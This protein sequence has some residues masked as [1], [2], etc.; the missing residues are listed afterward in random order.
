MAG[1]R[2]PTGS[3]KGFDKVLRFHLLLSLALRLFCATAI[4]L[5]SE[6]ILT[7]LGVEQS[8]RASGISWSLPVKII[9]N[10][11]S[12]S[13]KSVSCPT[14]TFCMAV[15]NYGDAL[16]YNDPTWSIPTSIDG[17]PYLAS[18]SCPTTTFCMAVDNGGYALFY[19]GTTWSTPL[20]VDGIS[21]ITF[22]SCP[23]TTFCMAVDQNGNAL[24]YNGTTWSTPLDVDAGRNINSVSCLTATFCMAVDQN[25]NALFYNGTNWSTPIDIDASRNITSVSCPTTT[26]CMAVDGGGYALSFNGSTWTT[27]ASI[28]GTTYISFVSC[29]TTTFCM[30]VDGGGYA[31]SFNGSTWTT[32]VYIDAGRDITSVSC[33]TTTFCMAVDSSGYAS[34]YN[35]SIWSTPINVDGRRDITSVSCPTTTFCMAVD[36]SGYASSYNG[37]TWLTPVDFDVSRYVYSVSC[38]TTTFCMAVDGGGYALSFNG[39]TW[40][41][42]VYAETGGYDINSVSCPTTT[43]CMAT[44]YYG[45]ALTFN[46]SAWSTP[47]FADANRYIYSLSCPTT[48]FCMAVDGGGNALTYNG[49]TWSASTSV[50]QAT[51]IESVSCPTTT[52]C[53]AVDISGNTLSY[54]GTAWSTPIRVDGTIAINF[55]SCPTTTFCMAV[56][57]N[58][59]AL[60]Y[61][62]PPPQAPSVGSLAPTSGAISGGTLVTITG[63]N[64]TGATA[65]DFGSSAA[66][67]VTVVSST[68]VTAISPPGSGVVNVVVTTPN[69]TSATSSGD[70]F[71]YAFPP[72]YTPV[73]PT[74]ICDTRPDQTGVST[75]QCN[76][77][78]LGAT[79]AGNTSMNVAVGGVGPVPSGATSVVLNVTV[80][81]TTLGGYLTIYP[82]GVTKPGSS[83]INFTAG[84]TTA[85]LVEVGLG[86]GG[87]VTVFNFNSSTDVIIDVEGYSAPPASSTVTGAFVA[88][89]PVRICDTRPDQTGVSTNEC[90]NGGLGNTQSSRTTLSVKIAG[91]DG[92]PTD[93]KAVVANLTATDT[94]ASGFF[95]AYG[96]GSLPVASNLNFVANQ[97]VS[98]R[99]IVPI[100]P[101]TGN[102][103]IYNLNGFADV[104]VDINGYIT[105]AT[106]SS[107]GSYFTPVT[108]ARICDT[109]PVS[110]SVVS[111]QCDTNGNTTL[112]NGGSIN[113]QVSNIGGVPS[114][115]T[116]VVINVTT[117]DSTHAGF[118]TVYPEPTSPTTPPIISDVN[119]SAGETRANLTIVKVG[120]NDSV[121]VYALYSSDLI[122]D[123]MGYYS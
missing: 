74:R 89:S 120:V 101:T 20:D 42:P 31:L 33:P 123:V 81:D 28:D 27:P 57:N 94:S 96:A 117:T 115:A 35:G 102:I 43:F 93:A 116:A 45:F 58:A 7:Y 68:Q 46:G 11:G 30:A 113:V 118:F 4:I 8:A 92:I 79:M 62:I 37:S 12:G 49:S 86:T 95:T 66:T 114:N 65:V 26:F 78:G 51:W 22:V 17:N 83:N 19:N 23:T 112:S 91:N 105:G 88:L 2:S 40:S 100:D 82:T 29:P 77:G 75:N 67:G 52:F 63:T 111:N 60:T 90:N 32:P 55:V 9:P 48:T 10:A 98:N 106:G 15:D 71:T 70:Q 109:R 80:T 25:G 5:L 6:A 110:S 64:L 97:S 21:W 16:T 99:V 14:S 56:D 69:G 107:S 18:V 53:M 84:E 61:G 85:N 39:T 3:N 104:I 76:N 122:I 103:Y 34:S 54:N 13:I 73:T 87:D 119:W 108:P 47:I 72:S 50:D 24:F 1:N 59:S 41:T 38:P 121:T 36:S 44:D